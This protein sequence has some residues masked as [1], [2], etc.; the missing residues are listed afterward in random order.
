MHGFENVLLSPVP[1]E[2]LKS[3]H[4]LQTLAEGKECML[5][6]LF[7]LQALASAKRMQNHNTNDRSVK[8][9]TQYMQYR[10]SKEEKTAPWSSCLG[11]DRHRQLQS[12]C[13]NTI[14]KIGL[15][16]KDNSMQAGPATENFRVQECL[17]H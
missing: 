9:K 14:L 17:Y 4:A 3:L 12:E 2:G 10:N 7:G 15:C 5:E 13:E 16:I 1:K 6:Q 8:D 11:T